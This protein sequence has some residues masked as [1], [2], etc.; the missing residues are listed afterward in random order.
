MEDS[1]A[2]KL[3][4]TYFTSQPKQ[5]FSEEAG[6]RVWACVCEGAECCSPWIIIPITSI[7]HFYRH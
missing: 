2:L 4:E 6:I 5:S 3:Q 7:G 1:G